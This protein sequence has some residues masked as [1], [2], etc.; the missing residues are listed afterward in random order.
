[1]TKHFSRRYILKLKTVVLEPK[2][3]MHKNVNSFIRNGQ[4]SE[5]I[6]ILSIGE[7]IKCGIATGKKNLTHI[8]NNMDKFPDITQ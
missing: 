2:N 3:P 1:M 8:D 7:W 5:A 4:R 6:Q